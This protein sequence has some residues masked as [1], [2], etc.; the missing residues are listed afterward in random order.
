M[1][2]RITVIWEDVEAGSTVM[3]GSACAERPAVKPPASAPPPALSSLNP[4]TSMGS[5][6]V[7]ETLKHRVVNIGLKTRFTGSALGMASAAAAI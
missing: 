2:S 4:L 3:A 1:G 7:E 5:S 6:P